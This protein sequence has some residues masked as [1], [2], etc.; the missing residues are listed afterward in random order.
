MYKFKQG[1]SII[2]VLLAGTIF[3]LAISGIVSMIIYTQKTNQVSVEKD[4]AM[5]MLEEGSVA[6]KSIRDRD[7]SLLIEG[8]DMAINF[9]NNQWNILVNP[10][11]E[12]DNQDRRVRRISISDNSPDIKNVTINV[13]YPIN[14]KGETKDVSITENIVNTSK[15]VLTDITMQSNTLKIVDDEFGGQEILNRKNP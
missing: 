13:S 4:L 11:P 8:N 10:N 2:E 5:K 1:Y 9:D 12:D 7:F 14:S 15:D 3:A 6:L